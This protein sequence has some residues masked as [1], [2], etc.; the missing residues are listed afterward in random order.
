MRISGQGAIAMR[1]SEYSVLTFD[2]F[3]TLIDWETGIWEALSPLLDRAPS[4]PGRET[5]LASFARI[6]SELQAEHPGLLYSRLLE[7]G[8]RRLSKEWDAE[9]DEAESAA[10]GR[11]V[12]DW[13]AFGDAAESLSEL[14]ESHRLVTLT[15]CDVASYRGSSKRLGDPW[16]AIYTAEDIG[17]YKPAPANFSYLIGKM[18]SEFDA[19]L[20]EVLHIAQSLFHD[21]VP[22]KAAGL[23][24]VWIDRRAGRAGGATASVTNSAAPDMRFESMAEF[25]HYRRDEPV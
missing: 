13:P 18:R 20:G 15:N 16:D 2:T 7:E 21:H 12:P 25:V 14:K 24:T 10:F 22:A 9:P 17:S 5:A 4:P 1:I 8:H 11:S 3:G 6:E 19:G 23:K